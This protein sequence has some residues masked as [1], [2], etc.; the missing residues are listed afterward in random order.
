MATRQRAWCFT[1][2][3]P[4]PEEL[5]SLRAALER[6]AHQ[7][8]RG[9]FGQEVG[10]SGTPHLQGYVEFAHAVSLSACKQRLGSDRYHLEIRRG[11]PFEAWSYCEKEGHAESWGD[12]PRE[13][14]DP[15]DSWGMA[16]RMLEEGATVL[17]VLRRW[18][19]HIRSI[20]ALE[21]TKVAIENAQA[22]AWRTLNVIYISGPPGCGKT[23]YVMESEGYKNVYRVRKGSNPWDGYN[24]Q[25]V[26]LFDEFRSDYKLAAML[27]WLD[28]Y[29]VA[30]PA[31]FFDKAAEFT[32]VYIVSNWDLNE[33]YPQVQESDP[34]TWQ[35][36]MR[37]INGWFTM[38]S[39]GE[40]HP[41]HT[42]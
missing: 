37:R 7:G 10:E 9:V 11:T 21:K 35:A 8:G 42:R 23:R 4:K 2:N 3:N 29:P 34:V 12:A 32:T 36:F 41:I 33:Q 14:E 6:Y 40:L 25:E 1:L 31:R 18:P 19:G 17:D 15:N 5:E 26:I 28:G 24:G 16:L 30:L 38:D 20:G 13:D 22:G 27:E 39:T